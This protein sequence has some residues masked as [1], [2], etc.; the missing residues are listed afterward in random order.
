MSNLSGK[1][2]IVTGAS[3]GVGKETV[4]QLVAAGVR[5]VGVARGEKGLAALREEV[6]GVETFQGDASD[7][8]TADRLLAERRPNFIVLAAGVMPCTK[9]IDEQSWEEFSEPW[10]TDLKASFHFVQHV[11]KRPLTSG[12]TVVLV[13]SGAGVGGSP[14][15][16]GYAGAKRMQWWLAGYAQQLS[17]KRQLGMRFL[18]VLPR[19]LIA[20]TKI[21]AAASAAYGAWLSVSSEDYMKRF[22]KPLHPSG[23]A[24]AIVDALAGEPVPS[25]P[26]FAVT[27]KGLEALA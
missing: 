25:A 16:G 7:P 12:S 3:S 24:A 4:K 5:V 19:Q 20:G 8:A 1:L 18:A 26:A 14:L 27:G 17:D 6:P 23:V 15:S 13:S 9:P 11:L 2:A 22:D 21:A 10:G